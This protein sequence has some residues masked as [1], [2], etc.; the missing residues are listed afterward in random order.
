MPMQSSSKLGKGNPP[1]HT[2]DGKMAVHSNYSAIHLYFTVIHSFVPRL[3]STH[4]LR[5][6][7]EEP[8]THCLH[9][10]Q[11]IPEKWGDWIL[12]SHVHDTMM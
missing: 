4:V 5:V 3:T 8:G 1:V 10:H 9:M 11:I 2:T 7:E 6:V 12:S